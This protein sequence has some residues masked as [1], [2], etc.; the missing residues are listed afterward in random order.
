MFSNT[1][2]A[3]MPETIG[4]GQ[5][6]LHR[7]VRARGFELLI[8]FLIVVLAGVLVA[9]NGSLFAGLAVLG[10]ATVVAVTFYR[11]DWGF[12][13]FVGMV[14]A[15]DQ[16]PPRGYDKSI[17]G[18]EYFL[19]LKSLSVFSNV[20]FAVVT[21]M[22]LHLAL[23][24]LV[25]ILMIAMGKRVMVNSVPLWPAAAA[26]FLWLGFSA[27]YGISR[28]GDFLPALWELRALFY[29][30]FM[31]FFVPQII[32]ERHQVRAVVWVLIGTMAFKTLQ[33][34]VRIL[35]LGF[36]FG[37]R[38]E[39]TNHE[40][41]LFMIALFFLLLGFTLLG[42]HRGQR[43]ALLWLLLPMF[44]VFI[45][46]QRRATY[47]A[48][49]VALIAFFILIPAA[50]RATLLKVILPILVVV[51]LYLGVFWNSTSALGYPAQLVKSSFSSDKENA[52]DRYYSN[53]YREL[54]DYNLAQ[55]I[56]RSPLIGIG[57]GNKY[58]QPIPLV[59][60]PFTLR[61]YIP[62]NEIFWLLVKTG[63]IGFFFFWFFLDA[64][65]FHAASVYR[66]LRD[67][68]LKSLCAIVM[69]AI[70]GQIV[71]SFFDLQLTFY[72]NMVFLGL[73]MGIVPGLDFLNRPGEDERPV[74][75]L[76]RQTLG[77]DDSL[78]PSSVK[79]LPWG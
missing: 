56:K 20:G 42:G 5:G 67:P 55:T 22:E 61:D 62:H 50:N 23:I 29:L 72:R 1:E 30:G 7:W 27:A 78:Q 76:P 43:R 26:L 36:A 51:G 34:L 2:R 44:V 57:F 60:I 9:S 31:Y 38:T 48:I 39:L 75:P 59:F 28:G 71:V 25:W 79:A 19:N 74:V 17:I 77:R 54:E 65:L 37:N 63:A 3:A 73:L 68:Y 52:A 6:A 32:Q 35:R 16:F 33:G 64:F 15:F 21:P 24:V 53:L 45:L 18:V 11:L 69:L 41:P 49:A 12:L 8:L 58:D 10:I 4:N 46:A 70:L 13:L 47:G 66:G 40:D 14:L